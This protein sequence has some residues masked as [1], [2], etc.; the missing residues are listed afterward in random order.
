MIEKIT[1]YENKSGESLRN[2][3]NEESVIINHVI[4]EPDQ[5]FP[6]HV[7]E[8]EVHIII[9]KGNISINLGNQDAHE[10]KEGK[11]I[12]L[13]KGVVSGI[14]NPSEN[15]TELFVVKSIDK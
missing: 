15:T 12:S 4:I 10:Y 1:D 13:P 3:V 9:I 8:H 2:L 14:S 6:A 11:M 7:T 5:S